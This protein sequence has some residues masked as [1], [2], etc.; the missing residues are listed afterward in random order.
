MFGLKTNLT[1]EWLIFFFKFQEKSATTHTLF[2]IS[3]TSECRSGER[4][5]LSRYLGEVHPFHHLITTQVGENPCRQFAYL[6]FYIK[7]NHLSPSSK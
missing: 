5:F 3:N 6:F 4:L 2:H 1:D 7:K